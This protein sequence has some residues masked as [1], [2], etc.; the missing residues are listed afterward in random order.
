[1]L[2]P[3]EVDILLLVML[4]NARRALELVQDSSWLTAVKDRHLMQVFVDEATDFSC[5]QLACMLELSEPRLRSWFACG[6]FRQRI[7]RS[8]ITGPDEVRWI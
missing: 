6:D 4:R 2:A 3:A 7:T 5:I 1:M 8:G